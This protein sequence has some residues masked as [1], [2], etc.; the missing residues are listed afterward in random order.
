MVGAYAAVGSAAALDI[1][2]ARQQFLNSCGT[3]H[4]LDAGEPHR[5]GPNLHDVYGR[6]AGT[7]ADFPYSATLEASGWTWTEET[8][9]PWLENAQA[10]HPGTTMNYRQADPA[11]RSLI[12]E[13]LKSLA[14][15]G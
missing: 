14:D 1:E 7:L 10:A 13:L 9:D 6:A 12:I 4:T 15:E 5:Q 8:L 2:A 11:K 3:C